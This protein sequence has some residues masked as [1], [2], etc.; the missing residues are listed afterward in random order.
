M[1]EAQY[2]KR[3][4]NRNRIISPTGWTWI[5]VP[6]NKDHKFTQNKLVEINN[7]LNWKKDHWNKIWHSYANAKYFH[8][9]KD[10]FENLYKQDW[11]YLFDLDLETIKKVIEW[12]GLK[13]Q[14]IKESEL[15]ITGKATERLINGCKAVGADTYISG[16]GLPGKKYMEEELFE[17]NNIKLVYNNYPHPTYPQ[18]MSP[19]FIPDLSIIDLLANAGSDSLKVI[20]GSFQN[21]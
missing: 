1:D 13:I 11:K 4:T 18:H 14:I 15:G 17:K 19:T 2:D 5:S 3:F 9:Y 16:S 10:Y 20:T 21:N 6:I 8:L 7:D 12:L